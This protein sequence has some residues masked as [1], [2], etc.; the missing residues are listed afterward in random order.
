M[1]R[2]VAPYLLLLTGILMLGLSVAPHHHHD[3]QIHFAVLE[4]TCEPCQNECCHADCTSE[5]D[6]KTDTDCEISQL[7]VFSARNEAQTG[8]PCD[9]GDGHSTLDH[10]FAALLF[11][12][13]DYTPSD[14]ESARLKYPP[15][16]EPPGTTAG[17]HVFAL[18]APPALIA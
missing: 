2:R 17:G 12:T 6:H 7:F 5:P 1:R 10:F 3:D 13:F 8:C 14:T 9:H 16:V 15:Y 4:C 18:R 11:L